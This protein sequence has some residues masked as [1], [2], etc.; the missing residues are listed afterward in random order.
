[1]QIC[2]GDVMVPYSQLYKSRAPSPQKVPLIY[3]VDYIIQS[4]CNYDWSIVIFPSDVWL[5]FSYAI[6]LA[7]CCV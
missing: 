2:S 4:S 5:M 1:M 6:P 3:E 7:L